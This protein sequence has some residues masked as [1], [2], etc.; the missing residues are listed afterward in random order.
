MQFQGLKIEGPDCPRQ[1]GKWSLR[2]VSDVRRAIS[3]VVIPAPG[4]TLQL[5][6][7]LSQKETLKTLT[8]VLRQDPAGE[9]DLVVR[10][11]TK[12]LTVLLSRQTR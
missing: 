8:K 2:R 12:L 3:N 5:D 10:S 6:A 1:Q 7:A 4:G 9:T 11:D